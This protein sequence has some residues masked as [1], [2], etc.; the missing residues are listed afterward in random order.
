LLPLA[1]AVES[2]Q[3]VKAAELMDRRVLNDEFATFL[4]LDAYAEICQ[5]RS[6]QLTP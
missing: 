3:L 6:A 5:G 1:G 2:A 4:T